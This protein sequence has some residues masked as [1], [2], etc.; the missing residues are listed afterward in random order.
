MI[1]PEVIARSSTGTMSRYEVFGGWIVTYETM[2]Q[3]IANV[4]TVFV[5]DANHDWVV[6]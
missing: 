6:E 1:T 5:A 2:H 3:G 4:S